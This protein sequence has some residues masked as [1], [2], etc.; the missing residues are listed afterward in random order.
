[1]STTD[2]L[3]PSGL[4]LPGSNTLPFV[5]SRLHS[6]TIELCPDL[7]S[8]KETLP[9]FIL[10]VL[11]AMGHGA[12]ISCTINDDSHFP[13]QPARTAFLEA[14]GEMSG[15]DLSRLAIDSQIGPPLHT[16]QYL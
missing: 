14:I 7:T 5:E 10:K 13:D 8:F 2:Q 4:I 12:M 11:Q 16:G 3:L 6:S 15:I 9:P 1:M